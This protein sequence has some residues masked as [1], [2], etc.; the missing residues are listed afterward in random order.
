MA[1]KLNN[2]LDNYLFDLTKSNDIVQRQNTGSDIAPT[3]LSFASLGEEYSNYDKGTFLTE[4]VEERRSRNQ[5]GMDALGIATERLIGKTVLKTTA[6]IGLLGGLLG[7][8]NANENYKNENSNIGQNIAAWIAGAA[9][10]GLAKISTD[11]EKQLENAT[12]LYNSIE[13][14]QANKVNVFNNLF[15]GDFWASDAV[16]ATSFLLSAYG[17]GIGVSALK[18]GTKIAPKLAAMGIIN[19]AAKVAGNI[20]IATATALQTASEAMFEAKDIRDTVRENKAQTQFGMSFDALTPE[21]QHQLNVEVA[22]LAARTFAANA[23]LLSGTNFLQ[24]KNL[25]KNVG[26]S[27]NTVKG[28]AAK[29]LNTVDAEITGNIGKL[30][31]SK[32]PGLGAGIKSFNKF[33]STKAGSTILKGLEGIAMEG[34]VEENLQ[35][36]IQNMFQ[37]NPDSELFDWNTLKGIGSRGVNNFSNEEGQKSILLGGLIG[38]LGG[39]KS[40]F[41]DYGNNEKKKRNAKLASLGSLHKMLDTNDIYEDEEVDQEIDGKTVKV[42]QRKKDANGNL[43]ISNEKLE[44]LLMKRNQLEYLDD[45]STLGEENKNEIL[46]NLAKKA[47]LAE[48]VKVHYDTATE[49]L[50]DD[51]IDFLSKTSNEEFEKLGL[52]VSNKDRMIAEMKAKKQEFL[53]LAKTIDAHVL[54]SSNKKEDIEKYNK[55]KSELYNIGTT[56]SNVKSEILR[57]GI[58]KAELESDPNTAL[59]ASKRIEYLNLKLSELEQ[60]NTKFNDEFTKIA[61]VKNGQKY[62]DKDWK[63]SIVNKVNKFNPETT[64]LKEFND[65]E[66]SNLYSKELEQKSNNI[67]NDFFNKSLEERIN[68]GEDVTEIIDD[69]ISDNIPIT[70]KSKSILENGL[71]DIQNDINVKQSKLDEI[72]EIAGAIMNDEDTSNFLP[73]DVELADNILNGD[74]SIQDNIDLEQLNLNKT[75]EKLNSTQTFEKKEINKKTIKELLINEFTNIVKSILFATKSEDFVDLKKL[76]TVEKQLSNMIKVLEEKNDSDYKDAINE[77]KNSLEEIKKQIEIVKERQANRKLEQD[78]ITDNKVESQLNELGFDK[79]I[80]LIPELADLIKIITGK[81]VLEDIKDFTPFE[82][83][84]YITN[85]LISLKDQMSKEQKEI[86]YN[87][88]EKLSQE[89]IDLYNNIGIPSISTSLLFFTRVYKNNPKLAFR[90]AVENL[91]TPGIRNIFKEDLNFEKLINSVIDEDIKYDV[92][93]TKDFLNLHK[94]VL[95]LDNLLNFV[96]G[97]SNP[98]TDIVTENELSRDEKT[99]VPSNQQLFAIKE[100]MS[101]VTGKKTFAYM[102]GYAG[103]GKTT[104]VIKWLFKVSGLKTENVYAV[105]HNEHST[106]TINDSLGT[107]QNTSIDDLIIKLESNILKN[108]ELIVIDEINALPT[109]TIT[110]ILKGVQDYNIRNKTDIKI[111]GMGDPNQITSNSAFGGTIVALEDSTDP[112]FDNNILITPLTVR[113][114]SNVAEVNDVQDLFIGNNR[115]LRKETLYLTSNSD[116]TLGSKGSED[117]SGIEKIL[118][119][120]DLNDGKTRAII[121]HPSDVDFWKNKKLGV[122][123]ISYVD[124]QGRTIDEVYVAIDPIKIQDVV[125]FNK[126]MYTA[127]SRAT[128]FIFIQGLKTVNTLNDNINNST[129][130]NV[131]EIKENRE[132]FQKNRKEEIEQLDKEIILP[133]TPTISLVTTVEEES[134]IENEEEEDV[135]EE[136]FE[137]PVIEEEIPIVNN[138]SFDLEYPHG[139][140]ISKFEEN[141]KIIYIPVLIKG[142]SMIGIYVKRPEGLLEVGVLNSNEIENLKNINPSL[143]TSFID[144]L[145]TPAKLKNIQDGFLEVSKTT[146][147]IIL[148]EGKI[149]AFKKA[150]FITDYENTSEFNWENIRNKIANYFSKNKKLNSKDYKIRIYTKKEIDALNTKFKPLPGVPYMVIGDTNFIKLKRKNLNKKEHSALVEPIYEFIAKYKEFTNLVSKYNLSTKDI[151]DI[152]SASNLNFVLD[153]IKTKTG[154]EVKLTNKELDLIKEIDNLLHE[155]LSETDTKIIVGKNV[156]N[157]NNP[158]IVEGKEV[159]GKVIEITNEIAKVKVKDEVLE[160]NVSD[161]KRFEKRRPGKAQH[162][163][164]LIA[165]GNQYSNGIIIRTTFESDGNVFSKGKNLLPKGDTKTNSE[166]IAEFGVLPSKKQHSLLNKY[167]IKYGSDFDLKN[168]S[169]EDFKNLKAIM[170]PTLTIEELENI[171]Q[172]NGLQNISDLLV[173]VPIVSSKENIFQDR[174]IN[175]TE[176]YIS[177]SADNLFFEDPLQN[178]ESSS[179]SVTLNPPNNNS[180][181]TPVIPT[182]KRKLARLEKN[183]NSKLGESKNINDIVSYLKKIDPTLTKEQIQ[184]VTEAE[185]LILAEGIESW[186]LFKDGII[187]LLDENGT[188]K[189]NVAKHELFHKIFDMMLTPEQKKLV[190]KKAVEELQLNFNS[191]E[192]EIEEALA[193]MYQE[194]KNK[195]KV[196]SFLNILFNRIKKWLGMNYTLIPSIDAFFKNIENQQFKKVINLNETTKYYNEILKDFETINN[197]ETSQNWIIKKYDSLKEQ[198][199]DISKENLEQEQVPERNEDVYGIIYDDILDHLKELL[200]IKDKTEEDILNIKS[201]STLSNKKIYDNMIKDLFQGNVIYTETAEGS[202]ILGGDWTEDINDAEQTNHETNISESVKRGLSSIINKNKIVSFRFAYLTCLETLSNL[203]TNMDSDSLSKEINK[204]FAKFKKL[205]SRHSDV[206]AIQNYINTLIDYS[207]PINGYFKGIKVIKGYKFIN[208]NTISK[209]EDTGKT[210]YIKR[211][212]N[213]NNATFFNRII[214]LENN[215]NLDLQQLSILFLQKSY[216]NTLVELLTQVSSLYRQQVMY[217]EYGGGKT[218]YRHTLKNATKEIQRVTIV[219]NLITNLIENL[220]SNKKEILDLYYKLSKLDKSKNQDKKSTAFIEEINKTIK[221]TFEKMFGVSLKSSDTSTKDAIIALMSGFESFVVKEGDI[222]EFESQILQNFNGYMNTLADTQIVEENDLR[223]PNYRR[224]DGKT[225][226]LFTLASQAINTL[227]SFVDE[228]LFK[229]PSFLNSD[230]FKQNIFN[231]ANIN[232]IYRYINFDG[233]KKENEEGG[234]RYKNE[235]ETDWFR[236]NFKYFFLSQMSSNGK[237][238]Q[239]FLTISNKPNIVSAEIDFLNWDKIEKAITAILKQEESRNYKKIKYKNLNSFEKLLPKGERSIE[240]YSKELLN[241]FKN[242]NVNNILEIENYINTNQLKTIANKFKQKSFDTAE[243]QDA[244]NIK[245]LGALYYANNYINSHQLNQ[246]VAGDEAFYKNSFDVIKRMSI[247][248]ATGYKGVVSEFALPEKYKS[249]VVEDVKGVLGNDFVQFLK[250][251]GKDYDIT[252]AQGFM[253]P[254]RASELRLGFGEAFNLGSIIKPV[255]FEIDENG[256]P[257]AVKYSCVELTDELIKIFPQLAKIR[258]IL[259]ENNV[260]EMVFESA[261]KVGKPLQIAKINENNELIFNEN[262]I[263][264]LQNENYRIQSNPEHNVEKEESAFPTQLGYFANFSGKNTEVTA[265]LFDAQAQLMEMGRNELLSELKMQNR[266]EDNESG[267]EELIK[268]QDALRKKSISKQ[269]TETDQRQNEFIA[270]SKLGINTP[271]LV[272]KMIINLSSFFSKATVAIRIPGGGL[273]LQSAFGT[274]EYY[275][276]EG[277][278]IKEDL[279]WRDKDGYAEV[280]LPDFWKDKIKIG[281][282]IMFDTMLGFRI[283]STELHSAIPLKVVGYYP[284]NKNVIIAPGAITFFHGSDYDVDKLYVMRRSSHDSKTIYKQDGTI[285]QEEGSM[286]GYKNNKLSKEW[287]NEVQEEMYNVLNSIHTAKNNKDIIGLKEYKN[288]YKALK[289]LKVSYYKNVVVDSFLKI[290]TDKVNEE[291]MVSPITMD[292]FKGTGIETESTFDLVSRLEGFNVPKPFFENFNKKEDYNEAIKAWE[293]KRNEYIFKERDLYNL[294]EQMLM[295]KDNFSGTA[296]TGVF[297]DMAKVIAYYFQS[298][299]DNKYPELKEAYHIEINGKTYKG[300]D[301]YENID[302]IIVNYDDKGNAIKSKPTITESIDSLVNAA[303]DNVKEQI[304]SIIG[305]TNNTG[306]VAVSM[307]A[308]GIPLNDIVLLMKQPIINLL[309]TETSFNRGYK[310]ARTMYIE[311]VYKLLNK[312]VEDVTEED[313]VK[314]NLDIENLKITNEL[315][316]NIYNKPLEEMNYEDLILQLKVL[317][318]T[319][320]KGEMIA[321]NI[322]KGKTAYSILKGFDITFDKLENVIETIDAIKLKTDKIDENTVDKTENVFEN[323]DPIMLPHINKAFNVLKTLKSKMERLFYIHNPVLQEFSKEINSLNI[324]KLGNKE[325]EAESNLRESLLQYLLSGMSYTTK[326][327]YEINN[328]TLD[329]PEYVSS[330]GKTYTGTDA[331]NRRFTEEIFALRKANPNNKFLNNLYL[332]KKT[333]TFSFDVAKNIDQADLLKLQLDFMSLKENGQ[334]TKLQYEFIKYAVINQGLRFG[335]SSYSLIIP[336]EMYEP[337]M[338]KYNS[339]FIKLSSIPNE[340]KTLLD[341]VKSNFVLQFAM[342]NAKKYVKYLNKEQY[343]KATN[344]SGILLNKEKFSEPE[345]FYTIGDTLYVKLED[346]TNTEWKYANVGD[347]TK[348]KGYQFSSINLIGKYNVNIAFDSNVRTVKVSNNKEQ[349]FTSEYKYQIGSK[350]RLLNYSDITRMNMIEYQIESV[351]ENKNKTFDYTLTSPTFVNTIVSEAEIVNSQEFKKL[352]AEGF[353]SEIALHKIKNNC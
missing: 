56:L 304:L 105:G 35:T 227:Q 135:E 106:K 244:E 144:S 190:Y 184:F 228:N 116:N 318:D 296:L 229:K 210:S 248:F 200:E 285:L 27:S 348:I 68:N 166:F 30:A 143:Y 107:T 198:M 91:F 222:E 62:F 164:N 117:K 173:P 92:S 180:N 324:F 16:D 334:Y 256:I 343:S 20:D 120:K 128:N 43:T 86:L 50:L 247:A 245:N 31:T 292:R 110:R 170:Y 317:T 330:N 187:Y 332:N 149:T 53:K 261:V 132:T 264:T 199:L 346:S 154:T 196:S 47:A 233:I 36:S 82:K 316:E 211:N 41:I 52:D 75:L 32:I 335:N 339:Y 176:A 338:E 273:V 257:R 38:G 344:F 161:L 311:N 322:G 342:N 70:A 141:E 220:N 67:E 109:A 207:Y 260:D 267:T 22:P 118:K 242:K 84:G 185:M 351:E 293:K 188:S 174:E 48:W 349:S 169:P 240:E 181:N 90:A 18:I 201:L 268:Q 160:V 49:N 315:L 241:L 314:I 114:R 253:T 277:Q 265:D 150:N 5:N 239:Q 254:K 246:L 252:D 152:I 73:E 290:I 230:F 281:D 321:S 325:L 131:N 225:A 57:L 179:I 2:E 309:N 238:I 218:N 167:K 313:K 172:I 100:L 119:T 115:D 7:I 177:T 64:T 11:I 6:G 255:H 102:K 148:A 336:N 121:V 63:K 138:N 182:A 83:I 95:A 113:Y 333:K 46:A 288:K 4:N 194:W 66:K 204:R 151:Y 347:F 21:Q 192:I 145:K 89:A 136:I 72:N 217:G 258:T 162:S 3:D 24:M 263:I 195:F 287:L 88:K 142:V 171:F 13:D 123:I 203:N 74:T 279:K 87:L 134:I 98:V 299:V 168:Y 178:I 298:T 8:D 186:G 234:V 37:N 216:Q 61:D 137:E 103:T 214:N 327:G 294:E 331:F 125:L 54:P 28:L 158:F 350:I 10:N 108:T 202:E 221:Q 328:S 51:K 286:I 55:R 29:G 337:L 15:D 65:F 39:T 81:N 23:I 340:F 236:R 42:K 295:H 189:L 283:P 326:E 269:N 274:T 58:E 191:S 231:G 243:E 310:K 99:V 153:K 12:P 25:M 307:I 9:D 156:K 345:M 147:L 44:N 232:K 341:Q 159:S 93:K 289:E 163:F 129:S 223:N 306:N 79:K 270:N 205:S 266:I 157:I 155:P 69:V 297:A 71:N 206:D 282:S 352:I 133:K 146:P 250:I 303:I 101:F 104:I 353:I 96:E 193:E 85:I 272:K 302:D 208:E 275:N 94:K 165:K 40:G 291:L 183:K 278:L 213:E 33:A 97:K 140:N 300:F 59:L 112:I 226:Y 197:F 80:V 215:S 19:K 219:N 60:V 209:I 319:I 14:K 126:A 280:V 259:E 235:S 308:M 77:Y 237:Y 139:V 312:N 329:E 284:S 111:I 305:F 323:V 271:F 127:T 17:T 78:R 212:K 262:S 301:Y 130:K 320:R 276:K 124:V 45:I 251:W 26:R 1:K 249:L 175:Y 76:E 34:F 224:I 122:E